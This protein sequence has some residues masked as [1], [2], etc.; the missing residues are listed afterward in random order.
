[1]SL[2]ISC[3]RDLKRCL[4]RIVEGF[5]SFSLFVFATSLSLLLP[6]RRQTLAKRGGEGREAVKCP[7]LCVLHPWVG[8]IGRL[9]HPPS[10]VPWGETKFRLFS[11][12]GDALTRSK[13]GGVPEFDISVTRSK[14][15]RGRGMVE[16]GPSPLLPLLFR[17]FCAWHGLCG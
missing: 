9:R 10:G 2:L 6:S 16:H 4:C 1:M 7:G 12:K 15:S 5:L 17:R 8:C 11:A 14:F 13:L 3:S